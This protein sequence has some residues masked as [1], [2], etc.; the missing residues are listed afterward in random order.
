MCFNNCIAEGSKLFGYD[1]VQEFLRQTEIIRFS[2]TVGTN[3]IIQGTGPKLGLIVSE[4]NAASLY[5][6]NN[7]LLDFLIEP[8]MVVEVS[9]NVSD[10]GEVTSK[11]ESEEV[12]LAV[13][14]LLENGARAFVVSLKNAHLNPHNERSVRQM[15][16]TDFPPHYLGSKPILLGGEVSLRA[17]DGIRT[18][19]AVVNAYL[20]RD[21]VRYLYKADEDVREGGLAS[22]LLIAH[23]NGGVARVAKTKAIDTYNSGPAAGL[24][25]SRY[26]GELYGMEN[27]VT[28]DVGGTSTDVGLVYGGELTFEAASSIAGVPVHAP[29]I[30]VLSV[31]GGGGS[32][33]RAKGEGDVSVGPDSA[34][35]I[36]GPACFDLG[37]AKP[38]VTDAAVALGWIDPDSFLGGRKKLNARKAH[39]VVERQIASPLD[40]S[41]QEAALKIVDRLSSIGAEALA[42]LTEER[43]H[44]TQDFTL[45]SFGG[46]GGLFCG[47]VARKCGITQVYTF[48]FSSVFSAFGLSSA[49]VGHTYEARVQIELPSSNGGKGL[50]SDS[51][52]RKVLE[53]MKEWAYRDMRGEGLPLNDVRFEAELEAKSPGDGGVSNIVL[54]HAEVN[55]ET[56]NGE[57]GVDKTDGGGLL[58][59][60]VR[61]RA[62]VVVSRYRPKEL[63]ASTSDPSGARRGMRDIH[64]GESTGETSVYDLLR[65]Q[66]G[67][68]LSGPAILESLD[69]TIVVPPDASYSV[70]KYGNGILEV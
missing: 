61:L 42:R 38:T 19:A 17:E 63:P 66:P 53:E 9:G 69:T 6:E 28:L 1:T 67:N 58:V 37:G 33:A 56:E 25:G 12:R 30:H 43:G 52:L 41:V 62:G 40:I 64:W 5:Q 46:G 26:L 29:L 68:E 10:T 11:V 15:I 54:A 7:P 57:V 20:H 49:D 51:G 65:L 47:E 45:F 2:T 36:P 23:A 32:I 8:E 21:M 27:I 70:D 35:A 16:R 50:A 31:G 44:R 4:G 59:E 14:K 18:N 39:D 3:A 13:R 55:G 34:G 48:P 60:V 22:P 24:M